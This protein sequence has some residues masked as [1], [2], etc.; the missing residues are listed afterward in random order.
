MRVTQGL[1]LASAVFGSALA[2]PTPVAAPEAAPEAA[3]ADYG[4][5]YSLS[6]STVFASELT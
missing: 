5:K 6:L 4:G 2:A 3:P 1:F